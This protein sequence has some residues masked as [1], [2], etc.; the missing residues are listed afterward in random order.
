[1]KIEAGLVLGQRYRLLSRIAVGGMG[2]VW[3]ARDT[4]LNII[5]AVKILRDELVGQEQFLARLR[6]EAENA[7]KVSHPNLASVLDHSET[8]GRG[9][10][11]MEYVQGEPMSDRLKSGSTIRIRDLLPISFTFCRCCSQGC[12][13]G[14]YFDYR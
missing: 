6:V 7:K 10:I 14:I 12:E 11:V 4:E 8:D 13:T 1:M 2:E 3:R 5:V 9:W